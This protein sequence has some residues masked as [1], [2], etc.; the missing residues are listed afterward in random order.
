MELRQLRYFIAVA[1]EKNFGLAARRLNVS[2]PPITRQIQKLEEELG[3]LLLRRTSKGTDLTEAGHAFLEDARAVLAH[4]ERGAERSRAA[5][6]GELGKIEIGY[7]GSVSYRVVP[8]VLEIFKRANPEV[9]LSLRRLSKTDQISALKQGQLHVGFGRY[10]PVEPDLAVEE[11]I[12][13][14]VA[15]CMPHRL[16]TDIDESNWR[17]V[18]ANLPLI[19]FPAAG[20]PNFADETLALLKRE[21]ANTPETIVA[22]DG[23]A[24]LMQVAIGAGACVVPNSMVELNWYGVRF[25]RPQALEA[26]CPVSIIYRKSDTSPLLRRFVRA[27]RE[28][29][30]HPDIVGREP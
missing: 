10:Y 30:L 13:E 3:V 24:A 9:E 16:G 4:M 28:F 20:R 21:R 22:E 2:Q 6:R 1:E 19:L 15:L 8:H 29:K 12:R 26:E 7:F 17:S 18:F 14:G 23:R 5:Q 27:M 25:F 11:V